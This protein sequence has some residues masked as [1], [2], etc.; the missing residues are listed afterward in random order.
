VTMI[1][2]VL[3]WAV[4]VLAAVVIV[5]ALVGFLAV[6]WTDGPWWWA[7]LFTP[8]AVFLAL[9]ASVWAADNL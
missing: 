8:F 5:A 4:R 3:T 1:A 6:V 2:V 9:G 7:A